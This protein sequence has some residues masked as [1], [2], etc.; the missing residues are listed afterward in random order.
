MNELGVPIA[1]Q[2]EALAARRPAAPASAPP[3]QRFRP[4]PHSLANRLARLLWSVVRLLLFRPSP[5]IAHGW[6][7]FLLRLF[8][9]RIGHR[10]SVHASARIWAPWNLEMG[11]FS[12]LSHNVDC[13]A[14]DRIRIG[15]KATVSQYSFLCAAGHDVDSPDMTLITAPI[16]I[17]E[18]AWIAADAF[19]G[20]G[21]TIGEGAVVGA[22]A[23]VFKNVPPWTIVGGNPARVIRERSRAV[24]KN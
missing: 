14:V 12:C 20:P 7:R 24:A 9:A 6:R 3:S 22:R 23:T 17:M 21:V 13:Y 1:S 16:V 15:A 18:H 11:D 5:K 4:S 19:I 8:G 10:A 2:I